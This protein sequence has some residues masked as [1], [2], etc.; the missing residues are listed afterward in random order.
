[1]TYAGIDSEAKGNLPQGNAFKPHHQSLSN[2]FIRV[3]AA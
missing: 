2:H 1:M 3:D